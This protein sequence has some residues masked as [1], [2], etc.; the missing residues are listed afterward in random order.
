[1]CAGVSSSTKKKKKKN[2]NQKEREAIKY[3]LAQTIH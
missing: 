3:A 1:M 2:E